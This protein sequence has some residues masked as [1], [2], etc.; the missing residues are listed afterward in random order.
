MSSHMQVV[1][2]MRKTIPDKETGQMIYDMVK[3]R[4]ADR[5]DVVITGHISDHLELE[6]PT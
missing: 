6:V 3:D 2:T 1:I 5:P 4:M